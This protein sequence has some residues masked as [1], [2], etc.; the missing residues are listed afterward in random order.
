MSEMATMLQN[1]PTSFIVSTGCKDE[2]AILAA[3]GT[4]VLTNVYIL[5]YFND[6]VNV[7]DTMNNNLGSYN[8]SSIDDASTEYSLAWIANQGNGC[9]YA[10]NGIYPS[11]TFLATTPMVYI[12]NGLYCYQPDCASAAGSFTC[13][14]DGAPPLGGAS[15]VFTI[16]LSNKYGQAAPY[17]YTATVSGTAPNAPTNVQ[18]NL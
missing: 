10:I 2:S 16:T 11:Y 13:Y 15:L 17:N 6:N 1:G 4:S 3:L 12:N 5:S 8:I 7:T 9:V 14:W 18:L